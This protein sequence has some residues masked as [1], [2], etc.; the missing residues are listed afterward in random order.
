MHVFDD[1]FS[2]TLPSYVLFLSLI[3]FSFRPDIPR[4]RKSFLLWSNIILTMLSRGTLMLAILKFHLVL[5]CRCTLPCAPYLL[6]LCHILLPFLNSCQNRGMREAVYCEVTWS[7]ACQSREEAF[8]F[9]SIAIP[10]TST[11]YTCIIELT[12]GIFPLPFLLAFT[13]LRLQKPRRAEL[14]Y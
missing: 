14:H 1:F 5:V 3:V 10:G 12:P 8:W 9:F 7:D 2:F 13:L 11:S 4:F 6:L